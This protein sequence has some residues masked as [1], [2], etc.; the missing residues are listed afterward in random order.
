MSNTTK[1]TEQPTLE[2]VEDAAKDLSTV[3]PFD[4]ANFAAPPQ[5]E[6]TAAQKAL[7]HCR[8]GKPSKDT[9]VRAH[10]D[11]DMSMEAFLLTLDSTGESYLLTPNAAA[12]V[13]H[14]GMVK[15][16]N[17]TVAI[18]RQLDPFLWITN[19]IPIEG[20]DNSYWETNRQ[21]KERAKNSWVRVASNQGNK[22]YDIFDAQITIDDPTWPDHTLRDYLKAGFAANRTITEPTDPVLQ[23]LMGLA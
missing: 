21:A 7:V 14:L 22:V 8:V 15:R 20:R 19:P 12:A 16:V 10:P 9:F 1:T 3:D 17:I 18:T 6:F 13:Q 4:P 5:Q 2:V 11:P 23:G